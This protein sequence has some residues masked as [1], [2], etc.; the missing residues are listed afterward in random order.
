MMMTCLTPLEEEAAAVRTKVV[1]MQEEIEIRVIQ[2]QSELHVLC[3]GF[4]CDVPRT[5]EP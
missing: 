4:R 1:E 3:P 5:F 2:L